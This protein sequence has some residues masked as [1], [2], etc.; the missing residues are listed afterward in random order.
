MEKNPRP[1]SPSFGAADY[2]KISLMSLAITALWQSLHSIILPIRILDFVGESQ[3]NTYLGILTFW[4]LILAMLAQ[5]IAGALSDRSGWALGRRRPYIAG[6]VLALV[7]FLFI[8]GAAPGYGLLFAG[9]A[10]MQVSSNVIQGPYQAFIPELVPAARRGL[11]SGVKNLAEILGGAILVLITPLLINHYTAGE[12]TY[13]LWLALAIPGGLLLAAGLGTVL[14]VREPRVKPV[15]QAKPLWATILST[16]RLD[17]SRD[18]AFV[19]FLISRLLVFMSLATI[20]QFALYFFQDVVGVEN[21]ASASANF[22]VVAVVGMMIA[23]YPAG[24]LCDRLGRKPIASGAALLGAGAV[25]MIIL[26]PKEYNLLLVPALLLGIALGAFS[27]TN[28]AMATD[29]V[30]AGEEARYLGIANMATAGGAALA[31]LIGPVID[32]FNARAFNL[33]Y[34][35]MLICCLVYFVAGGLLV[36]K[37][38]TGVRQ[39]C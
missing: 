32:F 38:K 24:R 30:P 37:V 20:Q 6:G 4:G 31:R 14:W 13:W 11:A 5:P 22:I 1:P 27:T 29:L 3:K 26:L 18:R 2:V 15:R 33:G 36:L 12:G 21:P 23:A 25:L 10:L 39:K 34:Q 7:F 19:W 8:F 17:L 16:F 28:W 9:Y 35:V